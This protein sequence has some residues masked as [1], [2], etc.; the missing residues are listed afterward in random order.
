[1]ICEDVKRLL[2]ERAAKYEKA[3][4][5]E[6]DPSFFMRNAAGGEENREATAFVASVLSFGRIDQFMPKIA[7]IVELARGDVSGWVSSGAYAKDFRADDTRAFYRFFTYADMRAFFDSYRKTGRLKNLVASRDAKDAI[8][9]I[10]AALGGAVVPRRPVSACK[11]LC[12]FVRWMARS[13]S[14]VDCGIWADAI[15]RR[16]LIMPLDAHVVS[17]SRRLGLMDIKSPSMRTAIALTDVMREVFPDDPLKGDF[18]LFTPSREKDSGLC[19][20]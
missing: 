18:A 19:S 13:G 16:T 10:C 11:K 17:E 12:M 5:F 9:A 3:E 7:W 2:A 15:D 20:R 1:M 8:S 14:E 4:Y 6:R